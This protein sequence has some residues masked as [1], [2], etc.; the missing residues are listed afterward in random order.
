[1]KS[2]SVAAAFSWTKHA[3][4]HGKC[5]FWSFPMTRVQNYSRKRVQSEIAHHF[6]LASIKNTRENTCKTPLGTTASPKQ[7]WKLEQNRDPTLNRHQKVK[8]PRAYACKTPTQ[9]LLEVKICE[10]PAKNDQKLKTDPGAKKVLK[11]ETCAQNT[12][13]AIHVAETLPRR[14]ECDTRRQSEV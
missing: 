5:N 11:R 12:Q 6:V 14:S 3:E 8:I 1:M 2:L 10:I 7:L 9:D 13:N 4:S